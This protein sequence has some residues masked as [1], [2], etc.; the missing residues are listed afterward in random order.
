[1]SDDP[2]AWRTVKG[3]FVHALKQLPPVRRNLL[4]ALDRDSL[5]CSA[6]HLAREITFD[7]WNN[8]SPAAKKASRANSAKQKPLSSSSAASSSPSSSSDSPSAAAPHLPAKKLAGSSLR[9]VRSADQVQP[10][11]YLSVDSNRVARLRARLRLGRARLAASCYKRGM[12]NLGSSSPSASVSPICPHPPC[13]RAGLKETTGH[14][15]LECPLYEGVRDN[16][17]SRLLQRPSF[18]RTMTLADAL[19]AVEGISSRGDRRL[20]LQETGKLLLEIDR[21]RH[22]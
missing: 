15:L 12:V 11:Y 22:L 6:M 10:S 2:A 17:N 19:G 18:Y 20:I 7:E 1:M 21:H 5:P 3:S 16:I 4:A 8:P 9:K 14:A 13:H